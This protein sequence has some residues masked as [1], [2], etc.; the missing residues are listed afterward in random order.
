M[1]SAFGVDHGEVSKGFGV[2]GFKGFSGFTPKN[3]PKGGK[4]KPEKLP[5]GVTRNNLKE[6]K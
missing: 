1:K 5:F 2:K 4:H 6:W 3:K